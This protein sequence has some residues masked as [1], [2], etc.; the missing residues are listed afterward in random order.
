[1]ILVT[2]ST[3]GRYLFSNPIP[4]VVTIVEM[5][6][7]PLL[8]FGAASLVQRNNDHIVVDALHRRFQTRTKSLISVISLAIG[9]SIFGLISILSIQEGAILTIEGSQTSGQL[10]LPIGPSWLIVG[11]GLLVLCARMFEQLITNLLDLIAEYD[12]S[13]TELFSRWV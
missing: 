8:I 5:Y 11:F 4:N 9:I 10:S 3:I 13:T 7:M 12:S 2:A 6:L 1:M